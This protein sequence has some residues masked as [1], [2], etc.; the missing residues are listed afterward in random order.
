MKIEITDREF[1]TVLA[2]LRLWQRHET[3]GFK[4]EIPFSRDLTEIAINRGKCNKLSLREIDT[5]C[6]EL[7]TGERNGIR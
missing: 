5:L 4:Y 6:E 7:N 2:A 3:P 1:H